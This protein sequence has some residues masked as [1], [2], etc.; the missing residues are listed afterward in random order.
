MPAH[1]SVRRVVGCSFSLVAT[2]PD[3]ADQ[4]VAGF[5]EGDRK[6]LEIGATRAG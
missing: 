1:R 2:S 5:D 4:T 3:P 6:E